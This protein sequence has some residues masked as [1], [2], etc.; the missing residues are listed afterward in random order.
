MKCCS[1]LEELVLVFKRDGGWLASLLA[2]ALP[3]DTWSAFFFFNAV[4]LQ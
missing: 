1:A 2:Q 3:G 4:E